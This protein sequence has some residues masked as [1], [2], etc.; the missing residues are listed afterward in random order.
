ME[1]SEKVI[2][3][4]T[5]QEA[6]QSVLHNYIRHCIENYGL[7]ATR[8]AIE[9]FSMIISNELAENYAREHLYKKESASDK[10]LDQIHAA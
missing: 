6:C 3:Q 9:W 7:E 10:H 4:M 8:N 1:L 2:D 5:K